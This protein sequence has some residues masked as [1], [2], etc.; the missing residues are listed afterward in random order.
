MAEDVEESE[1]ISRLV[2]VGGSRTAD[3]HDAVSEPNS[4]ELEDIQPV[5]KFQ[6][7]MGDPSIAKSR[8]MVIKCRPKAS[9]SVA[10]MRLSTA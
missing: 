2:C 4:D 6:R 9:C 5:A 8:S 7:A 1:A 3:S 10:T